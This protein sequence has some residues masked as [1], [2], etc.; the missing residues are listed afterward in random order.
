ML[1]TNTCNYFIV[2]KEISSTNSLKKESS[3]IT[4]YLQINYIY[5]GKCIEMEKKTLGF[6]CLFEFHSI[7]TTIGYSMPNLVYIYELYIIIYMNYM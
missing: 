5:I 4:I 6:V 2:C 3:L 7:S 1:N